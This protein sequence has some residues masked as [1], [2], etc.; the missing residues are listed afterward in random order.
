MMIPSSVPDL[1]S[2]RMAV[3]QRIAA[4]VARVEAPIVQEALAHATQGGKKIRPLITCLACEAAGGHW[5][6][7]LDAAVAV[8]LLHTSSLIHDDI[9][10][11]SPLRRGRPTL[12]TL[13]G[14][15]V[16]ILAGDTLIALAF[17]LIHE[18][19]GP[20]SQRILQI[21]TKAFRR[22]CEG[23]GFDLLPLPETDRSE[24][25]RKTTELKTAVLF[26]A[27]AEIGALQA[28]DSSALVWPL[29]LF[30][31]AIGMAFQAKDDVLDVVG[32]VQALGKPIHE[33]RR[34]G[35]TTWSLAGN[36]EQTLDLANDAVRRYTAR[37]MQALLMIPHSPA[38]EQLEQIARALQE[39]NS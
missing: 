23:Q 37:A 16:A 35:R 5:R 31:H 13:F 9:M 28:T 24:H 3:E 27:A 19:V 36:G 12:H 2:M 7:A 30:G 39:R 1:D 26:Q 32:S 21:F 6:Q 17:E 8:E 14:L 11:D 25:S 10:D 22:L 38:R 18:H 29:R 33:D 20:N 4:A 15:P 34:N